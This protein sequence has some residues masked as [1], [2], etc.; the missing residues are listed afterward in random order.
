MIDAY[1]HA[2]IVDVEQILNARPPE[3]PDDATR[4]II[5]DFIALDPAAAR[6]HLS[7]HPHTWVKPVISETGPQLLHI[8]E[9]IFS[10]TW[11]IWSDGQIIGR[12]HLILP[13]KSRMESRTAHG[14]PPGSPWSASP[15]PPRCSTRSCTPTTGPT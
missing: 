14:H 3:V 1:L 8:D 15:S 10:D 12:S 6:A 13:Q 5:G 7:Q 9:T 2:G 4:I 11:M